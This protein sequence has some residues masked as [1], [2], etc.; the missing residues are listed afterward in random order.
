MQP[1]LVS[2]FLLL[3]ALHGVLCSS[4]P[5]PPLPPAPSSPFCFLVAYHLH[6]AHMSA[7]VWLC[8]QAGVASIICRVVSA[9][10]C[11]IGCASVSASAAKMYHANIQ[12]EKA[13]TVAIQCEKPV[14]M[15]FQYLIWPQSCTIS[16]ECCTDRVVVV[17]RADGG[18]EAASMRIAEQYLTAF[19]GIAKAGT[20]LLLPASSN[21]PASM[22]A[23]ALSI[24]NNVSK[25]P[26]ANPK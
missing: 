14:A 8:C 18:N 2:H 11:N 1:L 9:I 3:S 22:V 17:R 6:A 13:V 15:A 24:Y 4:L 20:T 19:G 16:C 5:P 12:C 25:T 23:Q 10:C 26:L 7:F 21:D